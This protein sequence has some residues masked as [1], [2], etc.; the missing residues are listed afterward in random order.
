MLKVL[1]TKTMIINRKRSRLLAYILSF[2]VFFSILSIPR[3]AAFVLADPSLGNMTGVSISSEGILSWDP[4]EGAASYYA[5]LPDEYYTFDLG[6]GTSFDLCSEMKSRGFSSGNYK[7]QV[8]AK[9]SAGVQITNKFELM[10]NGYVHPA[11]A[12]P[13]NLKW[14]GTVAKWDPVENANYYSFSVFDGPEHDYSSFYNVYSGRIYEGSSFDC[15]K[16]ITNTTKNYWFCVS[17][18]DYTNQ[19]AISGR[20]DSPTIKGVAFPYADITNLKITTGTLSWDAYDGATKYK[21]SIEVSPHS[22]VGETIEG[23]SFDIRAF[24]KQHALASGNYPYTI[25]AMDGESFRISN[26]MSGTY[27]GFINASLSN[28]ANLRWDG[29]IA[30]WDAVENANKYS[31]SL[32][33]DDVYVTS[34]T[35]NE[36]SFD[37]SE[38]IISTASLYYFK[39]AAYDFTGDYG[40]SL[41]ITSDV[42]GFINGLIATLDVY[43]Y[44]F[45]E[46][47]HKPTVT[48]KDSENNVLVEGT[49]YEV[50]YPDDCTSVGTKVINIIGKGSYSGI[51]MVS[52]VIKGIPVHVHEWKDPVYSWSDDNKTVTAVRTCK[53]DNSHIETETVNTTSEV[54]TP[55]EI[56]VM[57]KT[58]YTATF[59]NTAFETQTKEVEDIPALEPT[60]TPESTA[61][62]TPI[63][64]PTPDVTPTAEVTPTPE[65]T[66]TA[67]PT[68]EPVDYKVNDVVKDEATNG[69][70]KVNSVSENLT[71]TFTGLI[72]KKAK[73]IEIPDEVILGGKTYQVT[74]IAPNAFKNNK[75]L[76]KVI[77]GKN[78]KKIGK[79]AFY[80]CKNLKT[81]IIKTTKLTKKK[82]GTD[83]FKKIHKKAKVSVPKK[84]YKSYKKILKAR[85]I[86][87]KKQKIKKLK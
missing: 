16:I 82:V 42:T 29:K 55:A 76:T 3:E 46:N 67:V 62:S 32:Y 17:A 86:K 19:Y 69:S 73:N 53:F 20:S 77:I 61:A 50:N 18:G 1:T 21:L 83:A 41:W 70:Y 63:T 80:G 25:Y 6:S 66:P 79:K 52:Y 87:G 27:E 13:T 14:D 35:T 54:T 72:N 30:K 33:K 10:Y 22:F 34:Q 44:M 24:C 60:P 81:V 64:T 71:V 75:K 43:E 12:D 49:D 31:V 39:V 4:Y 56:G 47:E 7:V 84:K 38:Y 51:M 59:T 15:K 28:P 78:V 2:V 5:S 85:G 9:N 11:L 36:T 65:A 68:E 26:T 40:S 37:F 58:T 57:G 23:T 74:E 8:Y 45:D 48:L